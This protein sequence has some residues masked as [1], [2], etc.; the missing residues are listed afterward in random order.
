MIHGA[1]RAMRPAFVDKSALLVE[2]KAP[3]NLA[4]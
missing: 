4:G 2:R 1:G 3:F